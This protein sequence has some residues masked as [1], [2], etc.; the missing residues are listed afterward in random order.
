MD[1]SSTYLHKINN[2]PDLIN[3]DPPPVHAPGGIQS[4]SALLV[5]HPHTYEILQFS[6]NSQEWFKKD[7]STLQG[8]PLQ[9]IIGDNNFESLT[10]FI[11]DK[12]IELF[13]R[14]VFT[15]QIAGR[16]LDFLAHSHDNLIFLET[17]ETPTFDTRNILSNINNIVTKILKENNLKNFCQ[18]LVNEIRTLAG[19]DRVMVY[20]FHQDYTSEI[21]V[22]AKRDDLPPS[23]HLRYPAED[24]PPPVR[25][26]FRKLWIR[27][28]PDLTTPQSQLVP[29]L[30][31]STQ[32]PLDITYATSK[33]LSMIHIDYLKN[34]SAS[35]LLTLSIIVDGKLWGFISCH[36]HTPKFI[37]WPIR[38]GYE[39]LAQISSLQLKEVTKIEDNI[40]IQQ[41]E[42]K[43]NNLVSKLL[44]SNKLISEVV[45]EEDLFH[46]IDG[47]GV[48]ILE[49]GQ[50][51]THGI[52]PTTDQLDELADFI[53]EEISH[54]EP[55]AHLWHTNCL[56]KTFEPAN[57]Y[58]SIATGVLAVSISPNHDQM[59]LWFRQEL[60]YIVNGAGN[61]NNPFEDSPQGPRLVPR[62]SCALRQEAIKKHSEKWEKIEIKAVE[63]LRHSLMEILIARTQGIK[64]LNASLST[65]NQELESFAYMASHDLQEPLR[66]INFYAHMI[67]EEIENNKNTSILQQTNNII[68]LSARM[69][70]L[71]ESLLDFSR[72]DHTNQN[73]K[74]VD[75]GTILQESIDI[76]RR[77]IEEKKP[78][79]HIQKVFPPVYGDAARLRQL[80]ANL[81]SNALK[82]ASADE[83]QIE[84]G[85]TITEKGEA[86]F[87][88]DNGIG[89]PP[90]Y[91]TFVFQIFKRLHA[92]KKYQRGSGVGLSIVKRVVENHDGEIWIKNNLDKGIT[93][94]FT[95]NKKPLPVDDGI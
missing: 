77:R 7:S 21:L 89:I 19:F 27:H 70:N 15:M 18:T 12:K 61:P 26:I 87:I 43:I 49:E 83:I 50:W 80:W 52:V 62:L 68:R 5:I 71:I 56:S 59:I 65:S 25:E 22:E 94:F 72:L 44:D 60:V 82:Y 34:M 78:L 38:A 1:F 75:M 8:C 23:L 20:K 90:Q 79:I 84:I 29:L 4:F 88:R 53:K 92:E 9:T 2:N 35:M 33:G 51:F 47:S 24:I 55:P 45:N 39:L 36:H 93:I 30:N 28:A 11:A 57:E 6:N 16:S 14:Y 95:L 73:F 81:I 48:A 41:S 37:P 31:P 58:S 69:K 63:K 10:K 3:Y 46:F 91:H 86:Y 42:N 67:K 64:E 17:E 54:N 40:Y 76:L 13:P 85:T 74:D 66:G 32:Q